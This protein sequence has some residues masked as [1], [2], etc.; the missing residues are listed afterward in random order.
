MLYLLDRDGTTTYNRVR[1]GDYILDPEEL[2]LMPGVLD[3]LRSLASDGHTL[4]TISNQGQ[5]EKGMMTLETCVE[6]FDRLTQLTEGLISVHFFC[7]CCDPGMGHQAIRH[8][9]A[10][11]ET[12]LLAG[13]NYRK[14][15]P[16]MLIAAMR[17][18]NCLPEQ[19]IMI[20]D[21][22]DDMYA[23]HRAGT[24]FEWAKDFFKI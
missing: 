4:V 16:G 15:R 7:P 12:F 18:F 1:N 8:D 6:T 23:A 21:R 11:Q 10:R 19:T 22:D 13:A 3:K 14:P 5:V 20:G 24:G 17:H 9:A 2:A